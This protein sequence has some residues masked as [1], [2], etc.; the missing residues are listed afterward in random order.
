MTETSTI[1][2]ELLKCTIDEFWETF[3][4]LWHSIRARLREVATEEFDITVEQFHILRRIHKG[5]DSVSQLAEAKQISRPAISR[6]V[7]VMVNK[8]LV[9]RSRDSYDRRNV[10]LTLT[11]EGSTLLEAIFGKN[12]A[13]MA[14]RLSSLE[15]AEIKTIRDA[16]T[17]LSKAFG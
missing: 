10:K 12:R 17:A 1:S 3:P 2:E 8:G 7:D 15:E 14:G 16:M 4:S 11:E 6:A 9:A 5:R 13:W